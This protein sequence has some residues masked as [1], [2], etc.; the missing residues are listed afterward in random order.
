MV[1]SR[2]QLICESLDRGLK[3]QVLAEMVQDQDKGP[4]DH[5]CTGYQAKISDQGS[6]K[7]G[8]KTLIC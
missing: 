4:L 3:E 6:R 7:D 5:K 1:V 8:Q 2:L